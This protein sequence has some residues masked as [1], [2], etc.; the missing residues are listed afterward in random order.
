MERSLYYKKYRNIG[1]DQDER[2]VLNN[3]LEK[4]K[5]GN[6][7]VVVGAN[8]S[9]KSNVLDGLYTLADKTLTMRDVTNLSFD[10]KDWHPQISLVTKNGK[11]IYAYRINYEKDNTIEF[12]KSNIE[13]NYKYINDKLNV[14]DLFQKF[15]NFI[16]QDTYYLN[17]YYSF[18]Y[19]DYKNLEN[20]KD[21]IS[22]EE[23][24]KIIYNMMNEVINYKSFSDYNNFHDRFHTYWENFINENHLEDFNNEILDLFNLEPIE[25]KINHLYSE[26]Y[27]MNFLPK[28]IKYEET[29]LGNSN[30]I[31]T[32][33]TIDKNP[34][35][36]NVLDKINYSVDN[37][38]NAY[39]KFKECNYSAILSTLQNDVAKKLSLLSEDFNSLYY[40]DESK[41]KFEI[42][43]ESTNIYFEIFRGNQSASL[44]YQSTGFRWFFNLYFNLLCKTTLGS[45]D[46]IIMDEPAT[47]LHVKGQQELRKFL[48]DFAINN[49]LTIIL[50]THSPFLID[51]NYL[52]EI[53]VVSNNDNI[54]SICNDFSTYNPHDPDSLKPVKEALTVNNNVLYDHDNTVI[55][56]EGITDYNY[57]IAFKNLLQIKEN[58]IFL[59]IEGVGDGKKTNC[60]EIQ[61]KIS[62]DLIKINKRNPLLLCDADSAGNSMKKVNEVSRLQ[63]YT[64]KDIDPSFTEIESLFDPEDIKKYNLKEKRSSTSSLI[65]NFIDDYKFSEKTLQ[66]FNKLFDFLK[67]NLE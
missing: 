37:I 33:S 54:S 50:A 65:K 9:G 16:G 58:Y 48:K 28:V 29:K 30:L 39:K 17:N 22:K 35:F 66:N 21:Q 56:V 12:P 51:M 20:L 63:V 53:R 4:G 59:P 10:D 41:Y 60:K 3:T 14:L 32:I 36:M 15:V 62:Q 31:A 23:L 38:K 64:L 7:I 19:N 55:F 13:K 2:L 6:L 47:N 1:L 52:D 42:K 8:N 24:H 45:G 11:D 57:L 40:T 43:F 46:I 25:E 49:D 61:Q 18:F 5:M 27:E 44:D 67:T 26:K 34:F